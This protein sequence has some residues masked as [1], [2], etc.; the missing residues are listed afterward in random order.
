MNCW[1]PSLLIPFCIIGWLIGTYLFSFL[2]FLG[3]PLELSLF[4]HG[5]ATCLEDPELLAVPR[6]P[7]PVLTT[8]LPSDFLTLAG[9]AF[10]LPFV[11]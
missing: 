4:N 7:D 10:L 6:Y 3:T 8:R 9:R 5:F 2:V 11:S 1:F